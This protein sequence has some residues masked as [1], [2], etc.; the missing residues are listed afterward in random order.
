MQV[1]IFSGP[2]IESKW[3]WK[4]QHFEIPEK[5]K[6]AARAQHGSPSSCPLSY[7]K[8]RSTESIYNA[9]MI[10]YIIL[11]LFQWMAVFV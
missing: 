2:E 5:E 3:L 1:H 10:T 6:I 9:Y 11:K 4:K 7:A 8:E